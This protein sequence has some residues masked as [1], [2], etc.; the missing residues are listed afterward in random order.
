MTTVIAAVADPAGRLV[1]L[2][3]TRWRHVIDGHPELRTYLQD[4]LKAVQEPTRQL[5][6]RRPGEAWYY[7]AGAGPSRWLKVVVAYDQGNGRILT[8]FARRSLP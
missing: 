1:V 8:A 4:V 5:P 3:A 6:G 7:L 2:T